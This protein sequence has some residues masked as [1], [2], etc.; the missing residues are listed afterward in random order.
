MNRLMVLATKNRGKTAELKDLL[1][2]QPVEVVDLGH[3]GPTPT[4]VEDTDSF[5]ENAYQKAWF[6][7]RILGLPALADDSGLVVEA[8][9]GRPGIM[10]ARYAGEKATDAERAAGILAEMAGRTDRR[11]AFVCALVLAVPSGPA[12]TWVGRC[13]GEITTA[14]RGANGFGYDPIF[15]YPAR[16]RTFAELTTAEKNEISH[17]GLAL[18]QLAAEF[19]KVIVWLDQRMAEIEQ[20]LSRRL[21]YYSR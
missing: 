18:K 7:A 20:A 14:P 3:F 10:S 9:D 16:G 19:P 15:Y 8:L 1:A 17:R 2:G 6:Y 13:E 4:P 5:G 12:L 21:D 11:A